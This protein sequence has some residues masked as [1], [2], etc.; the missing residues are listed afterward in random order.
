[1]RWLLVAVHRPQERLQLL[2]RLQILDLGHNLLAESTELDALRG[3]AGGLRSLKQLSLIG[4]HV[5][6]GPKAAA[7]LARLVAAYPCVFR[8]SLGLY[9]CIYAGGYRSQPPSISPALGDGPSNTVLLQNTE[10]IQQ[11]AAYR[12]TRAGRQRKSSRHCCSATTSA[13]CS[14]YHG[15]ESCG[16]Q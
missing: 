9:R 13:G 2:G 11:Q 6:T 14:Y 12:R 4:N 10:I 8:S 3:S 5:A 15:H 1:M 16:L 7:S